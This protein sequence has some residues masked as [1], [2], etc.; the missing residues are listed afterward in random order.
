[1]E[2]TVDFWNVGQG[3]CTV[4]TL[5]DGSLVIIDTGPI[6][7]P[8]YEWIVNNP[9]L[10]ID[11]IIITHNDADHM[12]SLLSIV[13]SCARQIDRIYLLQDGKEGKYIQSL[14]KLF[15]NIFRLELDGSNPKLI[16]TDDVYNLAILHPNLVA[17]YKA[18]SA[19]SASGIIGLFYEKE[20]ITLVT[21]DAPMKHILP[22]CKGKQPEIMTGPHHGRPVDLKQKSFTANLNKISPKY[23]FLS[24]ATNNRYSHPNVKYIEDLKSAGCKTYCSQLTS[25]CDRDLNGGDDIVN[26]NMSYGLPASSNISCRGHLRICFEKG[27]P[28]FDSL[29][30]ENHAERIKKLKSPK[31]I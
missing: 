9:S 3:D 13:K 18:K 2:I 25:H 6:N 24:L 10:K 4:I 28:R 20:L 12:G 27:Q 21:G 22:A 26:A 16:W 1:V 23:V 31:C 11:S 7:S 14:F 15:K 17:N 30:E 19:N 5:T 8:I 29:L